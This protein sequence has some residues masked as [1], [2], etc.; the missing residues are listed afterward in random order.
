MF[1]MGTY[2]PKLDE[3]GRLILPA[4][5]RDRLAEG[6]VVTK[7]RRSASTSSRPTSSGEAGR[8]Q[9]AADLAQR[10]TRSGSS[11]ASAEDARQAGPDHDP[12]PLLEYAAID[13]DVVVIGAMDRVEIWE[14]SRSRPGRPRPGDVR[15][16][17]RTAS[18]PPDTGTAPPHNSTGVRRA[19]S[20]P[21]PVI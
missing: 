11:R 6:L 5:F 17:T 12:V 18:P 7:G 1:F 3:K 19:R 16:P 2:T 10:V 15:R 8:A 14:P 13:R 4:K 20:R 9:E 21:A